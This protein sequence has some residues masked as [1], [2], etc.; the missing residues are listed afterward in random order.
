[1]RIRS[2][3]GAWVR[4]ARTSA[5]MAALAAA[6][7]L[8][9]AEAFVIS[10]IEIEGLERVT[11]GSAL[12]LL[13]I[14]VGDSFDEAN[15]PE[16]I[17]ELFATGLFDDVRV[18][19]RGDVLVL[20]VNERPAINDIRFSG[21]RTINDESLERALQGVGLRRG[22]VFDREV[23]ARIEGEI[24]QQ[25]FS[26]GRY[27]ARIDVEVV[28]LPRNRVDVEIEI[29]EGPTA[30]IRDLHVVGN[31]AFSQTRLLR[32][33]DSGVGRWWSPFSRRD[34]YS[35]EKLA[36][37]LERLRAAYL[38][39]G[40]LTFDIDSTQVMLSP[41]KR[42]IAITINVDEGARYTISDVALAGR[43]PVDQAELEALIEVKPGDTFSR[44]R[45]TESVEA[46][47]QRLA[48]EGYAFASVDPIPELD[49]RE[50][51][52]GL[53][54][55]VDPGQ[56]IYVR[57]IEF[58]GF[59]QTREDVYRR[60]MRQF[61][62]AW[63]NGELI[64]RSRVRLQRLAFVESVELETERVAGRE[65]QVDLRFRIKERLSGSATVGAGFSQ[66]QGLVL[67]AGLSQDNFLGSGNRVSVDFSTSSVNRV[68]SFDLL[69]PHY[70]QAGASRG[71]SLFYRE[72]DAAEADITRF[73]LDRLGGNVTYGFPL[74]EVDRLTVS[75]GLQALRLKTV[76]DTPDEIFEFIDREGDRYTQLTLDLAYTHDTRDR[77]VFA[78]KGRRHRLG[79]SLATPGSDLPYY[80]ATYDGLEL[81]DL[82][83]SLTLGLSAGLGY[84]DT[85]DGEYPFFEHFFAGGIRSVRGFEESSLGPRDSRNDP[86]GGR[87]RTTASA[88]L[89]FPAFFA[90]DN[91][92]MRMSTFID[93]G[94]V[95]ATPGDFEANELRYSAG[96]AFTWFSPLGPLSFA[97]SQPLNDKK[98]DRTQV[99]QF[100]LG[101]GF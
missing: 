12:A 54:I 75:P 10:D 96:L 13:P 17:R 76:S 20:V 57:R 53:T 71:F 63:Y 84:A 58:T 95:Y 56:K 15:S 21:N 6:P 69:N 38:D 30:R 100:L 86:F 85:I 80:R 64:E 1:M 49:E 62:G 4:L 50:Q 3:S 8:A 46:I 47:T 34:Q 83:R 81:F 88:E 45:V 93:G 11:A 60:E 48:K 43:F 65:D 68:L 91:D 42:D 74:S 89:Y 32:R 70:T 82:G 55:F 41:D 31:D 61:E 77:T 19:R 101:A 37:D 98:D 25:Y 97:V 52:V 24:R 94:Q 14:Q 66:G 79:L 67:T 18:A 22:R 72:V 29:F 59:E 28:E 9:Q 87:F 90:R 33:F 5:V 99:F 2:G 44:S 35:R 78:K 23:L 27:N 16:L 26:R 7:A 73:A 36:G 51:T 92:A 39:A 40:F